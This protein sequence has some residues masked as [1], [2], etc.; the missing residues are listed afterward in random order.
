MGSAAGASLTIQMEGTTMST[1]L[2]CIDYWR[3][4]RWPDTGSIAAQFRH[5]MPDLRTRSLALGSP[6]RLSPASRW[7]CHQCGRAR[8]C[9]PELRQVFEATSQHTA[10]VYNHP[11]ARLVGCKKNLHRRRPGSRRT[12]RQEKVNR[13]TSMSIAP[14][15]VQILLA[16]LE[17]RIH[18]AK[19]A[20]AVSGT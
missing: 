12:G 2:Q 3:R 4:S 15:C 5:R 10:P 7:R 17:D 19:A 16:G 18:Y 1:T 14:P 8:C 11:E 13:N 9:Q 20:G 6:S